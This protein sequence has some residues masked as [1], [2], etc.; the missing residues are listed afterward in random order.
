[1]RPW[2]TLVMS[3]W[4]SF[5]PK[6]AEPTPVLALPV[7]AAS[8]PPAS[9]SPVTSAVR[10]ARYP[11]TQMR[12]CRILQEAAIRRSGGRMGFIPTGG[13]A[14]CCRLTFGMQFNPPNVHD[15]FQA[16]PHLL[17]LNL[18]PQNSLPSVLPS[19]TCKNHPFKCKV[20]EQQILFMQ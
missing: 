20:T 6:R 7:T 18:C 15:C 11:A 16:L 1:M 13:V 2:S 9:P 8:P 12:A 19:S 5:P 3:L 17:L 14:E 10:A 4:S